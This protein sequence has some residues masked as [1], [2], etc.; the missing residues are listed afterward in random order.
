M[1]QKKNLLILSWGGGNGITRSGAGG[2]RTQQSSQGVAAWG[3]LLLK[4][5]NE[6]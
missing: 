4:N 5:K 2:G 3:G 1:L 6:K